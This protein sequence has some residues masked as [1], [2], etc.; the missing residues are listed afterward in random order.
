MWLQVTPQLIARIQTK[1]ANIRKLLT[2][3]L[4][5]VGKTHPQALI[6][7]LTVA[8]NS[9]QRLR[10][11]AATQ[12]LTEM[13]QNWGTLVDAAQIVSK[14]LVRVA[15]LWHEVWHGGLEEASRLYFGDKSISGML[16]CLK[17]LHKLMNAGADTPSEKAFEREHGKELKE[18][19]KCLKRFEE[20][21]KLDGDEHKDE[22]EEQLSRAW[23]LYYH[24][25]RYIN[26]ELQT[27]THLELEVVSPKLLS[28][29]DLELSV[30]GMYRAGQRVVRIAEFVSSIH[31]MGSKQKPRRMRIKG[32]DGRMY[33]FLLKG[34]E[35]LRQ[36]ERVM[37]LFGLINQLFRRD[38]D[39]NKRDD[40]IEQY[41]VIPLSHK[42][43]VVQWVRGVRAFVFR[44]FVT[45][46]CVTVPRL[47]HRPTR[48]SFISE[49]NHS[50]TTLEHRYSER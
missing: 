15:I 29:H 38:R 4:T 50:N 33:Q 28:A 24:V 41:G 37:Q 5:R 39:M 7:A 12:V 3:L 47:R 46:E 22:K 49:E 19:E 35:D 25:F 13:R 44:V 9:S 14:E 43:G 42:V 20:L 26:K 36:D 31:V 6:Y 8:S 1:N 45:I 18:A 11:K 40:Y 48:H 21:N 17:P 27:M 10:K 23:D 16:D 32:N 2:R 30:P 34:H